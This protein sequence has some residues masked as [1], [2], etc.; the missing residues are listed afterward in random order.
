MVNY[1]FWNLSFPFG[2]AASDEDAYGVNDT[3]LFSKYRVLWEIIH[4]I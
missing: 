1:L 2:H 3:G 4:E